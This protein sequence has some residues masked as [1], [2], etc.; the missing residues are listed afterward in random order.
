MDL[1]TIKKNIVDRKYKTLQEAND[2]VRLVWSNCMTYNADGSD[3]FNLAQNLNKKWNDKYKKLLDDLRVK[4]ETAGTVAGGKATL[5]E[6]RAFAKTLYKISKEDLGK[7]LVE[8]EK[9]CPAALTRNNAE[10]EVEFNVDK[11][12]NPLFQELQAFVKSCGGGV[13]KPKKKTSS[14]AGGG[15]GKRQKS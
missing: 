15:G 6:K 1:G 3:F 13:P 4:D 8:V 9:Q 11:L 5:D 7:M 12:P 14:S 2:D 10:D